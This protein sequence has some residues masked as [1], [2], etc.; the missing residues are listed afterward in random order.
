MLKNFCESTVELKSGFDKL[1]TFDRVPT[2]EFKKLFDARNDIDAK[3]GLAVT[4]FK[5]VDIKK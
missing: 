2:T 4:K 3:I 5:D 1:S